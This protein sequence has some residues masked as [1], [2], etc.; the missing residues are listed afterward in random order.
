MTSQDVRQ[1]ILEEHAML[2]MLL[3]RL[4][5]DP[6]V[7]DATRFFDRLE[8]HLD[9]EERLLVPLLG[10]DEAVEKLHA[11]HAA[12][13]RELRFIRGALHEPRGAE[14]RPW[15]RHFAT[16]LEKDMDAEERERLSALKD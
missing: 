16:R 8:A 3:E 6:T 14:L 5:V 7:S 12:Q 9:E 1:R 11:E 13:R 2:R 4:V 10:R 15:L